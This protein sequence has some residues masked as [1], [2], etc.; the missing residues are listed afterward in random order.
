MSNRPL[1]DRLDEAITAML[2]NRES[3]PAVDAEVAELLNLARDLRGLPDPHFKTLLK[4]ELERNI[5]MTAS[6]VKLRPGFRTITPY[7]LPSAPEF[8]DFLKSVFHAEETSRSAT[9]PGRFHAEVR[10]DDSMVMVGVGSD[11]TMPTMIEMYVPNADEVYK[12][13]IDAGCKQLDPLEDAHWDRG[14]RLGSVQDSEGNQWVIASRTDGT[15]YI[16]PG[17]TAL[18][19]NLV[20]AGAAQLVD[21]LKQAFDA[22]ELLRYDWPGGMYASMRIGD[23]TIGVSEAG[24]HE[25]MRPMRAMIYMYVPDCDA[26]Y[27]QALRAGAKSISEPADMPYGDR[28]GAVEDQWGN[29]WYI[30]TPVR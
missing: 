12:R 25:W 16:P 30:A 29:Q 26:L 23:S 10:I 9:G 22:S 5:S 2:A 13:A 28:T 20:T 7:L 17:R 6:V 4:T 3:S 21:F 27:A 11:A 18:A 14:L 15:S 19:A 1:I 8:M 24:N